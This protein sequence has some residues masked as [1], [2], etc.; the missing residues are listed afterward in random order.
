MN[1]IKSSK[2]WF[3][4]ADDTAITT[5]LPNDN[6]MLLNLFTK[7]SSWEDLVVRVDKCKTFGIKKMATTCEQFQ[8]YLLIN[9][10]QIPAVPDGK[11]FKYL[12]KIFN[13]TMNDSDIK[14]ELIRKI[15]NYLS[16]I[17]MLPVKNIDKIKMVN[18]YVIAKLNG[19]YRFITWV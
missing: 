1:Q 14:D 16:K 9:H 18:L 5:S 7:W 11:S 15:E 17:D 4:F 8:P 2:H 3:Q 13:F 12:G 6:Q 10:Q 19:H